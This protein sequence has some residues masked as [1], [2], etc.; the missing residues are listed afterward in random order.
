M[1]R[2]P[3]VRR[4]SCLSA[5]T[6]TSLSPIA[7]LNVQRPAPSS[8]PRPTPTTL[9]C[10]SL[11]RFY[12]SERPPQSLIRTSREPQD[13]MDVVPA[14]SHGGLVQ[15]SP[16]Q[17]SGAY[18][19]PPKR[20]YAARIDE[21]ADTTYAPAE[22]AEGLETV[23]GVKD[24]WERREHWTKDGDFVSFRP[25]NKLQ[26]PA[27]L[28]AHVRRAVVEA[29]I[30]RHAGREAELTSAWSVGSQG[31][32][33]RVM[34]IGI[35]VAEDGAVSVNG[36]AAAILASLDGSREVPDVNTEGTAANPG[37]SAKRAAKLIEA[38][39]PSWKKAS[40]SDPRIKFAVTKRVFQLTGHLVPDHQLPTLNNVH[41]L[42]R[43]VQRPPK[44]KTL[45][46]EIQKRNQDLLELPNVTVASKRV[47][48]GDKEKAVG[49]FKLIEEEFKKRDLPLVGHGFVRKSK[50]LSHL[51]GG[52]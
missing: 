19:P 22:T 2:I 1:R 46:Q 6:S 39:D 35:S 14:E 37:L 30:L 13:L 5:S 12:S 32:L 8:Q 24:W 29:Y 21:I 28:E 7:P 4:P 47:T 15:S 31:D 34:R 3:R 50:E 38:W 41:A 44:P 42:L 45:T 33:E 40:L 16:S 27:V 36:D 9:R 11:T 10:P 43:L 26:D 51:K 18:I 17:T 25:R 23:G 52:L 48:R 49:R 20:S